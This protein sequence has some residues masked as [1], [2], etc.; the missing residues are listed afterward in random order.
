LLWVGSVIKH[1]EKYEKNFLKM[2]GLD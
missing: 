2:K 1:P